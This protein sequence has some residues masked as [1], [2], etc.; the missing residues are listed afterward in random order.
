MKMI[1]AQNVRR[2]DLKG[3]YNFRDLG[4][5]FTSEGKK[6]N[7]GKLFRSDNLSK[8]TKADLKIIEELNIHLV[9]DLRSNE[10]RE[11]KPNRLPMSNG[12]KIENIEIADSNMS[13]KE[14]KRKIFF[15]KLE[16]LDLQEELLNAYRLAI[17]DYQYELS[18]FFE[19]LLNPENYPAL[20]LCN[21]GKD[22]TGAVIALTLMAIGVSKNTVMK[23]YMLSKVYLEPMIKRLTTKIRLLSLF[24][25]DV[26]Q[27]GKFLDTRAE[28]LNATFNAIDQKYG[29]TESFFDFLG[30]DYDKR[31]KLR[32][33]LC[34]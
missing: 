4:G 19:L 27:L 1:R 34:S 29:S 17:T 20:V 3:A 31:K 18:R 9:I 7:W 14:L 23:D 10:E 12:I 24:R 16:E 13:H 8:I 26:S 25:A 33:L 30:I 11:S 15:G 5:Y 6:T 22:R 21:A 32:N 2:I 28:Y